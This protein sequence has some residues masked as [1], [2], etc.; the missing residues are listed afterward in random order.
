MYGREAVARRRCR[1]TKADCSPCRAW[2]LWD[3]PGQRCVSHAGRHHVGPMSRQYGPDTRARYVPCQCAA[4]AW[5]HRPGGGRCR[6]PDPALD[7]V[8]RKTKPTH[9]GGDAGS[10]VPHAE[11]RSQQIPSPDATPPIPPATTPPSKP[12]AGMDEAAWEKVK[13]MDIRVIYGRRS[14]PD[15]YRFPLPEP[16][17]KPVKKIWINQIY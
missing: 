11:C 12:P 2:A 3:D 17:Q 15:E 9:A 13:H 7:S 6:W 8:S 16:P 4:Y 1:A 10:E 14:H 5:P